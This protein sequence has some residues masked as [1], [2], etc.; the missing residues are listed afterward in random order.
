MESLFYI[1][2]M[3]ETQTPNTMTQDSTTA[4]LR[5]RCELLEAERD[6]QA[7]NFKRAQSNLDERNQEVDKLKAELQAL[8]QTLSSLSK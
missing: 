8:K 5:R 4:R 3:N 2:L 7:D 1:C 6:V